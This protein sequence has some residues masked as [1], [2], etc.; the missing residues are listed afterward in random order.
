MTTTYKGIVLAGGS[1]SRLWPITQGVSKQLLPV[2]DKPMIY[3]PLSVLLLS[4]IREILIITTPEDNAG[5]RRLLGDGSQLGVRFEYAIQER[6]DGLAKAFTIAKDFLAGSP[7]CLVLGDNIFYGEALSS[8][9]KDAMAQPTGGTIFGCSVENPKQFG[10]IE[11]DSGG[12]VVSVEEKPAEPKSNFAITGLYFFDAD[13][14]EIAGNVEPSERG[15]YEITSVIDAYLKRGTLSVQLL[16]RGYAWLDS[17]THASLLDASQFV[18]VVQSRQ[19]YKIACLEE[20][21]FNN[22]WINKAAVLIAAKRMEKNDYGAYL[23][24]LVRE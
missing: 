14:V 21:A 1:G 18:E 3:Y 6:P 12:K 13:V 7:V 5:F 22:G 10:V 11:F 9:L 8:K 23:G 2:Y 17:G 4:G 20:I 15:E 24:R 19:G 16:G